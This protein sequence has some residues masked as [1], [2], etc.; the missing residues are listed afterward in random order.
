MELLRGLHSQ[1]RDFELVW[2]GR[3]AF[4][5]TAPDL[6]ANGPKNIEDVFQGS[7]A[8]RM[9]DGAASY[10]LY[11]KHLDPSAPFL[12]CVYAQ[13]GGT[14]AREISS[15]DR[16][17]PNSGSISR[18]Q[19]GAGGF[20]FVNSAERYIDYGYWAVAG[21]S[22]RASRGLGVP[23]ERA[24]CTRQSYRSRARGYRRPKPRQPDSPGSAWPTKRAEQ[25]S[26]FA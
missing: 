12:H 11:Q 8:F 23:Q 22:A 7:Y 6:R 9:S 2:E 18:R 4:A 10:D 5:E 15:S 26:S 13:I 20:Q 14:I 17:Q 16:N 24:M 19:G 21:R 25:R 3:L 1:I